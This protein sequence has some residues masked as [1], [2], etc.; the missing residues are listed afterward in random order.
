MG[1]DIAFVLWIWFMMAMF[2]DSMGLLFHERES[3][4]GDGPEKMGMRLLACKSC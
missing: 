3:L 2:Q 4:E 1:A